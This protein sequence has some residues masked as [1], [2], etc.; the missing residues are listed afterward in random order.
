MDNTEFKPTTVSI[1]VEMKKVNS[2]NIQAIGYK[3][4]NQELYVQYNSG[5]YIYH[6]VE[7]E[8]YERLMKAESKGRFLN[9]NIKNKYKF[10]KA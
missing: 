9:E 2:S 1:Q 5:T 3:D 8:L 6:E 10:T 7:L 4:W